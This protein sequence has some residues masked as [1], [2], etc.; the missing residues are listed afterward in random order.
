[1]NAPLG[2][3]SESIDTI[4]AR[5]IELD[6]QRHPDL[7]GVKTCVLRNGP[8]AYKLAKLWTI[9]DRHTHKVH[10]HALNLETFERTKKHGWRSK[11]DKSITLEDQE[12]DEIHALFDFLATA[13]YIEG[14]AEYAIIRHDDERIPRILQAISSTGQRRELLDQILAWVEQDPSATKDLIQFSSENPDRSRSLVAALNY[15]HYSRVLREFEQLIKANEPEGIYQRFLEK[16]YWIFGSEFCELLPL[17]ELVAAKQLDFP[18][19]RTVDGYLEIIEIKRPITEH[20][21]VGN[22][23][24]PRSEVTEAVAQAEEYLDL[25][26]RESDRIWRQKE[27]RSDKVRA[28]VVIGR[29]GD[30]NQQDALR[31]YNS[32]RPRVEVVTF[33]QLMRIGQRIL[34]IFDSEIPKP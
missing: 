31:R 1:M 17:R 34:H 20:L 21:F 15:G 14:N 18:L 25:L 6:K 10:H 24:A 11:P 2:E 19:R 33:D 28:T 23:L 27:V 22:R 8:R 4:I 30:K 32:N 26:D 13:S 7:G 16:N 3:H 29:D 12:A 5:S 9:L